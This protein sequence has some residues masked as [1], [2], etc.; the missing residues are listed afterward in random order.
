M[1]DLSLS[2]K[3]KSTASAVGLSYLVNSSEG[4]RAEDLD[5]FELRLFKD[6]ELRLVGRRS[7]GR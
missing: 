4:A 1:C 2:N 5:P 3:Q 6:A 7:A